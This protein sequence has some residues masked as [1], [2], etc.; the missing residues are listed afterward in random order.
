MDKKGIP[1]DADMRTALA[2]ELVAAA[3]E[4]EFPL[5]DLFIDALILPVNVAQDH[6][7][8]VLKTIAA[9]KTLSSP[10]PKTVLGLSNVSQKAL[11]RPLIDRT[12]MVMAMAAGLD[13]AICNVEDEALMDAIATARILLNQ[14]VYADSYLKVFKAKKS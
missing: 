14:E 12:Y 6:A 4:F 9:V 8:E 13:A 3:D 10:P 1:K 2:M 7:P 11:D 5:E